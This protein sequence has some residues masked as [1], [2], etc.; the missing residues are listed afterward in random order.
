MTAEH[1][2]ELF[3]LGACGSAAL[4]FLKIRE[5]YGKVSA[6]RFLVVVRCPLLWLLSGGLI[7]ASGIFAWIVHNGQPADHAITVVMAGAG[8]R[9]FGREGLGALVH[10]K[11]IEQGPSDTQRVS[12]REVLQ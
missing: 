10:N 6:S 3:A 2:G 7:V 8:F 11:K 5:L 4:E 1:F 12:L 9:S